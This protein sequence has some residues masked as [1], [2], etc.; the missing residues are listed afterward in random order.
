MILAV[1][2]YGYDCH[3]VKGSLIWGNAQ[4]NDDRNANFSN[5]NT[6]YL[7]TDVNNNQLC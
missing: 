4:P 6:N 1:I 7:K 3:I 5:V 2:L